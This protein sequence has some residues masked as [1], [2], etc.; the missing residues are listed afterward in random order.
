M[1]R[2][3]LMT[4][5]PPS[6]VAT[7]PALM[8]T[9]WLTSSIGSKSTSRMPVAAKAPVPT[10]CMVSA[11]TTVAASAWGWEPAMTKPAEAMERQV[12]EGFISLHVADSSHC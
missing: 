5:E 2:I 1:D 6:L 9:S 8:E 7:E 4:I 11:L 3:A 10:T 12:W